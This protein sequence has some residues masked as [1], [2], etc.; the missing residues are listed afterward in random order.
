MELSVRV[1]NAL[2]QDT[3]ARFN[4]L[5]KGGL[6]LPSGTVAMAA[7][8]STLSCLVCVCVKETKETNS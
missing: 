1:A 6:I 5:E 2:V 7:A 4:S 3:G 8:Q